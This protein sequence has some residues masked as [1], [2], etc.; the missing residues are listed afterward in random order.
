[1]NFYF[2]WYTISGNICFIGAVN[3]KI[4]CKVYVNVMSTASTL[5]TV[6][7]LWIDMWQWKMCLKIIHVCA[8]IN[9]SHNK[10]NNCTNVKII[11]S[12]PKH[13]LDV[14]IWTIVTMYKT[15]TS[16]SVHFI[17]SANIL[18]ANFNV[19]N[20]PSLFLYRFY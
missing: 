16:T 19:F 10:A 5:F 2:V 11:F 8:L 15:T 9:N 14:L 6:F 13:K 12:T 18:C 4:F 7:A 20:N 1:M 17:I 3:C